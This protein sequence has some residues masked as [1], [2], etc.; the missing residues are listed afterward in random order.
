LP[1]LSSN[2]TRA[3]S[4]SGI[5]AAASAIPAGINRKSDS[6]V[7]VGAPTFF[8]RNPPQ[9]FLSSIQVKLKACCL[10]V[11]LLL[12]PTLASLWFRSHVPRR[13]FEAAL[14]VTTFAD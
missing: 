9:E 4:I 7:L 11:R 2:Q 13:G 14:H 5:P 1:P 8:R 10:L 3:N 12:A 6:R